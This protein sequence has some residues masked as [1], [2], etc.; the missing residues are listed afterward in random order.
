MV[1]API[2]MAALANG[3]G[4]AEACYEGYIMD[5]FCVDRGTLLDTGR[6]TLE[7]PEGHTVH[8]LA[9]VGQC[10]NSPFVLLTETGGSSPKF[11]VALTLD[12]AGRGMAIAHARSIGLCS[13]C[14]NGGYSNPGGVNIMPPVTVTGVLTA[15][16]ELRTTSVSTGVGC[17]PPLPPLPPPQPPAP[18]PPSCSGS[19]QFELLPFFAALP[20]RCDLVQ[21]LA[22][23]A[24]APA[25][26][27]NGGGG[28]G[29]LFEGLVHSGA[30]QR[31][32]CAH[33]AAGACFDGEGACD[34]ASIDV[35]FGSRSYL[36]TR[37][38]G[39]CGG[40]RFPPPTWPVNESA[41]TDD[42]FRCV[43]YARGAVSLAGRTLTMTL[44]LTGAG[45][46][47]NA[48]LYLVSMPQNGI[49]G[50]G[51]DFYCDA[52]SVTGVACAEMDLIEANQVAWWSAVHAADDPPG[53]GFG[54]AHYSLEQRT[55]LR[56]HAGDACAYGPSANC[57]IDTTA[58][59][60]ARFDFSLPLQEFHFNVTLSQG[61]G[62]VA[63]ITRVQYH[64]DARRN[65]EL[66][67]AMGAGMTVV[68]SYWAGR[69]HTKSAMLW[70]DGACTASEQQSW[71]CSNVFNEHSEWP[72]ICKE[73]DASMASCA[74]GPTSYR[75]Y[76]LD[77]SEALPPP[78]SPSP[79][80]S[81]PAASPSSPPAPFSSFTPT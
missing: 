42:S 28:V 74:A 3:V 33:V 54:H 41:Y 70:M 77:L 45:C 81:P 1:V 49:Q 47:C 9:D 44:N 34:T 15:S 63:S 18:P 65:E 55:R 38:D 23:P 78:P 67:Q 25:T 69:G 12:D 6:V 31:P 59:F 56:S 14:D 36:L 58:P 13:T 80:T 37:Y 2:A 19:L 26:S 11:K 17:A 39:A 48:A 73:D 8:C 75:I 30:N 46:G 10:I 51:H 21:P 20:Q 40:K 35:V 68:V 43:D 71:G 5:R 53:D 52:N 7:E 57:T 22:P 62:R 72:W 29:G 32:A 4:A 50:R 66:R 27:N 60:S 64:D 61:P 79:L 16:G 24:A 76:D